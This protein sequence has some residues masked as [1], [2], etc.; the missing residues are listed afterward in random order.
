MVTYKSETVNRRFSIDLFD[1]EAQI[2]AEA[3]VTTTEDR[4]D[5]FNPPWFDQDVTEH[6]II[7]VDV[8]YSCGHVHEM[9][10]AAAS[11]YFGLSE[12]IPDHIFTEC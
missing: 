10:I 2:E 11:I 12:N 4:G 5:Y 6:E 3:T 7:S 1:G 9:G 8:C